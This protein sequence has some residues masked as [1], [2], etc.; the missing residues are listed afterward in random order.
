MRINLHYNIRYH[1]SGQLVL[2]GASQQAGMCAHFQRKDC[3]TTGW[4]GGPSWSVWPWQTSK[5][6]LTT[7]FGLSVPGAG[8]VKWQC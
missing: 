4:L 6:H 5:C 1:A 2:V 8:R 3:L 7:I